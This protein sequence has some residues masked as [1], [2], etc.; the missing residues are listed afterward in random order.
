MTDRP[1]LGVQFD[2]CNVY[3]RVYRNAAATAYVGWC[4]RCTRKVV[5]RIGPGGTSART[6]RA[7]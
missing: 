4:P 7:R 6:F 5:L 2:C 1:F 3:Q